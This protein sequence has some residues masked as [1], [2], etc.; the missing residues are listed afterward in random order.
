MSEVGA[1]VLAAEQGGSRCLYLGQYLHGGGSGV[2]AIRV[3]DVGN[4]T[5]HW[6]GFGRITPLGGP[7]ADGETTFDR[8]GRWMGVS[9]SGG[10][11]D[12]D[13]ITG[14]GEL[15]LP[16]PEHSC[17]VHYNQ[18]HCGPV[19]GGSAEARFKGGQLM[20]RSGRLGLGGDEDG[21]LG[22]GTDGGGGGDGRDR[23]GYGLNQWGGYCSKRNIRD[24][25]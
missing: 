21:G 19:Y 13:G 23:Y 22:S 11:Y 24:R 12:G 2:H 4:E 17:A 18:A 7:Q 10:S 1:D 5:L 8:T 14:G 9:K 6:E 25:S 15:H 16:P 20:V 3:R